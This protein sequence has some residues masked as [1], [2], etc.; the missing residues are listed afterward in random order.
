MTAVAPHQP[1]R[2]MSTEIAEQPAVWRRLLAEGGAAGIDEAAALIRSRRP[3]AV[4]FIARGTSDHA[5]LYAKY[6]VEIRHGVPAGLVSPS[7]MTAY[8][9]R[10]G[11]QEV[12][13]IGVSQSGGSPDLVRSL[14]VGR[15]QGALT[16]AITNKPGSPLAQAALSS[17]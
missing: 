2:L 5:A 9:A 13:M 6:L 11:L 15:E 12:L 16:L 7:T 14:E 4:L 3:R 1:G 10:P 8:G 17:S